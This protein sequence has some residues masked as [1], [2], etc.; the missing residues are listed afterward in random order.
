MAIYYGDANGKAQEVIVVGKPGPTGPQGPQGA[1][2]PQGPAGQ[3]GA[4]ITTEI[5]DKILYMKIKYANSPYSVIQV[6]AN[7]TFT[8]NQNGQYT[9][10]T[11]AEFMPDSGGTCFPVAA[12]TGAGTVLS[13]FGTCIISK[14]D[15]LVV[16]LVSNTAG[17]IQKSTLLA[18][19]TVNTPA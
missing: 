6:F 12:T 11:P 1:P 19:Y 3:G 18:M 8:I 16:K 15:N 7:E 4:E 9:A 17:N 2:G 5:V 14:R 10:T 13:G